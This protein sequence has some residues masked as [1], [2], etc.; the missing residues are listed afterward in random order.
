MT[1]VSYACLNMIGVRETR[2]QAGTVSAAVLSLCGV[3][4]ACV[5][6]W[7]ACGLAHSS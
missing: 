2:E 7:L 5:G 1:L 3:Q 6:G 4:Q